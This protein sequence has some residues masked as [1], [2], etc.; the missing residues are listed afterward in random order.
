MPKNIVKEVIASILTPE[1][2]RAV[3][4]RKSRKK[5]LKKRCCMVEF[6][7]K[8]RVRCSLIC[9]SIVVAVF[10]ISQVFRLLGLTNTAMESY[11]VTDCSYS[12]FKNALIKGF[13]N[14]DD[15]FV[16]PLERK[17]LGLEGY[18]HFANQTLLNINN[19]KPMGGANSKTIFNE[20]LD[21]DTN[22]NYLRIFMEDKKLKS[23]TTPNVEFESDFSTIGYNSTLMIRAMDEIKLITR[24]SRTVSMHEFAA[25]QV[26]ENIEVYS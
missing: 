3:S 7:K 11:K 2:Q 1:E 8:K 16:Q 21:I 18:I 20:A 5:E 13:K 6:F 10:T 19:I 23:C 25:Q 9:L 24:A 14:T 12:V 26:V 15:I 22:I 4:E 17:F